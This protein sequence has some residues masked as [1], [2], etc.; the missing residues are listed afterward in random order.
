MR[1]LYIQDDW[2]QF[3]LLDKNEFYIIDY[4]SFV[5]DVNN[6]AIIV[7]TRGYSDVEFQYYID[8][9]RESEIKLHMKLKSLSN[10]KV[11]DI[12]FSN[13]DAALYRHMDINKNYMLKTLWQARS[14]GKAVVNLELMLR[15]SEDLTYDDF[16]CEKFNRKYKLDL[17]E[18][19]DNTEKCILF[20]S[21]KNYN[22]YLQDLVEFD[23]EYRVLYFTG[24]DI[25]DYVVEERE[26]YSV[27]DNRERK[28]S[29]ITAKYIPEF[30]LNS[31]KDFGDKSGCPAL[32]FDIAYNKELNTWYVF[33]Y[34]VQFGIQYDTDTLNKIKKQF[35]KAMILKYDE[36]KKEMK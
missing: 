29:V 1:K 19:R 10:I 3:V 36:V 2:D 14:L 13:T 35:T 34:S 7:A 30:I 26:G 11:P 24:S 23:K 28:H 17:G 9:K 12:M 31:I 15:I 32:S 6:P 8:L 5:Y 20:N 16:D 22:Y 27:L 21:L 18:T 33:E 25:Y 4:K